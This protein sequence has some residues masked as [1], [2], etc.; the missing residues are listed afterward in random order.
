[1]QNMALPVPTSL[2]PSRVDAFT[3]CPLAFRFASID[4]LPEPPSIHTTRGSLVHRVLELLFCRPPE[5]RSPEAAQ[6]DLV[7][8]MDE[9]RADEDYALLGLNEEGDAALVA[10]AERLVARYFTME[11]PRSVLAIGLE[12]RLD[13]EVAGLQLRGIIDRLELDADGELVVTDYKT[14]R[15]PMV[16]R[17]QPRLGGVHFY[18]F[19]CEQIFGRR[20]SR[21]QLL[22]LSTGEVIETRP[23]EQ[24][25]RFLPRRT[26]AVY[27]AVVRACANEDFRPRTGPLCG[28]CAY[29]TWC[30][31]FGGDPARAAVEAPLVLGRRPVEEA[32]PAL[33]AE[34]GRVAQAELPLGVSGGADPPHPRER[35]APLAIPA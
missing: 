7:Q 32:E 25:V 6:A 5:D 16:N 28:F 13:V 22:Y 15:P 9:L 20:P 11:D 17:E 34:D 18:A 33:V 2:S 24:S 3:S 27:Q 29:K 10:D 8:A 12:L 4:R 23:S 30:P 21:I 1:M 14:G 19:L 31:A 35:G 26:E